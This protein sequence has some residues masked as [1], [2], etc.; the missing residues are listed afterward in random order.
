MRGIETENFHEHAFE[1]KADDVRARVIDD[2]HGPL[3]EL[4]RRSKNASV[5]EGVVQ[6]RAFSHAVFFANTFTAARGTSIAT[7]AVD[8]YR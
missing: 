2:P 5:F 7:K 4:D 8:G 1:W 3:F 6:Q